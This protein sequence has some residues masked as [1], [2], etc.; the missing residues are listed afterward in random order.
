MKPT[1]KKVLFWSSLGIGLAWLTYR[2]FRTKTID[3]VTALRQV[4]LM[5]AM[6]QPIPR[7]LALA[8][9]MKA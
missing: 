1:M 4:K 6:G 3:P 2:V 7:D 5:Q 9:G 8:A